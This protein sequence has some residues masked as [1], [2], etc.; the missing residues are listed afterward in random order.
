ME[1]HIPDDEDNIY[2][3]YK[4]NQERTKWFYGFKSMNNPCLINLYAKDE[5]EVY[6]S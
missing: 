2:D 5:V 4:L 1:V 6:E 3:I